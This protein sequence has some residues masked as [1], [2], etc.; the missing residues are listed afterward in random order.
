MKNRPEINL[1][2]FFG[3]KRE[4]QNIVKKIKKGVDK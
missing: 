3:K 1:G 4:C 2:G